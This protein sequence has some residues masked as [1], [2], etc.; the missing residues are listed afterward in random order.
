MALTKVSIQNKKA[1][2]EY[3]IIETH[4]AGIVLTGTEIKS[5]REAKASIR[6]A[7]CYVHR[8]EIWIKGMTI[9]TYSFGSY[10]N[11]Q[12]DRERKLLLRKK[13]ILKIREKL[14]DKGTTLIPTK[15]FITGRGWAKINFGLAR[16]KKLHDKRESI[17]AR[18]AKKDIDRAIKRY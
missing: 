1:F 8:D 13:E 18:D 15:V 17:K 12:T 14:K 4:T 6:E 10:N 16:G 9:A 2:H 5:I 7:Y 3:E 11:H